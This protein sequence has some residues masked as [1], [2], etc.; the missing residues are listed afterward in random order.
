MICRNAIE[1]LGVHPK[2]DDSRL[3]L[4]DTGS[5]APVV[6]PGKCAGSGLFQTRHLV[7]I[8]KEKGLLKET[9]IWIEAGEGRED[10]MNSGSYL[11]RREK[12]RNKRG[13]EI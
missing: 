7:I 11:A 4:P 3:P 8:V 2:L 12:E 10:R 6:L 5:L 9:A 1:F 13:A